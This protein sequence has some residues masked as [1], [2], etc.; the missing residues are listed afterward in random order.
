MDNQKIIFNG[1]CVRII[2][3]NE[4]YQFLILGDGVI[5]FGENEN[6]EVSTLIRRHLKE[7]YPEKLRE[8]KINQ[9]LKE[10]QIKG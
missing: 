6:I 9:C 2:I 4:I 10:T 5:P 8:I 7:H 3:E 1:E